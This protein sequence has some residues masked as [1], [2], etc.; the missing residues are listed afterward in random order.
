MEKLPLAEQ[1]IN[2]I[3]RGVS[4]RN[5][6]STDSSAEFFKKMLQQEMQVTYTEY[7]VVGDEGKDFHPV[8]TMLDFL[9]R[10]VFGF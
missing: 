5:G 7:E 8:R 10:G 3:T 9:A 6:S 1:V 2:E 4:R